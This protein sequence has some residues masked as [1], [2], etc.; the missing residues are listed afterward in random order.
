MAQSSKDGTTPK[1]VPGKPV[2]PPM[3]SVRKGGWTYRIENPTETS[4][5]ALK[6]LADAIRALARGVRERSK[7]FVVDG[8]KMLPPTEARAREQEIISLAREIDTLS[9]RLPNTNVTY[10][11]VEE[12]LSRLKK[13]GSFPDWL[14]VSNVARA[15]SALQ[16]TRTESEISAEST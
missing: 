15:I 10:K 7:F 3:Q 16:R 6:E 9:A 13:I 8:P 11:D 4:V 2:P 14:L 5:S 12:I 1:V